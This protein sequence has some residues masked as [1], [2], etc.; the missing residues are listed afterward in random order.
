MI[1]GEKL[2]WKKGDTFCI[3]SWYEFVHHANADEPVY[4]YNAH[5]K[6]MLRSLGFYIKAGTDAESLVSS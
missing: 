1:G 5:D 4:L 2:T 6:P 3:P